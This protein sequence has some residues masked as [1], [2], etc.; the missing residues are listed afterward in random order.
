MFNEIKVF[1]LLFKRDAPNL[2]GAWVTH[3]NLIFY[4]SH[5]SSDKQIVAAVWQF[6]FEV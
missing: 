6:I 5:L 3:K 2:N 4:F 1:H